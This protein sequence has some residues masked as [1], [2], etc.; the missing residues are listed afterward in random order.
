MLGI[1][2]VHL[3]IWKKLKEYENLIAFRNKKSKGSK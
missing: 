2:K 3:H 1:V